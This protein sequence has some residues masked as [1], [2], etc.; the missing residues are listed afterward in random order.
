M[1]GSRGHSAGVTRRPPPAADRPVAER[2]LL[3]SSGSKTAV[4]RPAPAPACARRHRHPITVCAQVGRSDSRPAAGGC[5]RR[6]FW[7]PPS[8]AAPA[9]LHAPRDSDA[10]SRGERTPASSTCGRGPRRPGDLGHGPAQLPVRRPRVEGGLVVDRGVESRRAASETLHA[11]RSARSSREGL[12]TYLAR[13][14]WCAW[15]PRCA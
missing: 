5:P 3:S 11:W 14:G 1:I 10:R 12:I 9:P 8:R 13:E 2:S 6:G 15:R 4:R 7:L